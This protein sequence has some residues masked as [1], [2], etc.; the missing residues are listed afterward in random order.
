MQR[1]DKLVSSKGR[2]SVFQTE[3]ES[4]NPSTR[5]NIKVA[6]LYEECSFCKKIVGPTHDYLLCYVRTEASKL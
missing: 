6:P 4:S 2:T 3:N 5:T 1:N